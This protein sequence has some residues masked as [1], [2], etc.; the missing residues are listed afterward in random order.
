MATLVASHFLLRESSP[1]YNLFFSPVDLYSNLA[2]SD[3]DLT[4]KGFT[5][6]L[7]VTGSIPIFL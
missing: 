4:E 3:F 5:K 1:L 2:D 7:E 6:K